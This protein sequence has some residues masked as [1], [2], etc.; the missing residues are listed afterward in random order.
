VTTIPG[1]PAL[2]TIDLTDFELYRSGF[3][4]DVFTVL[5]DEAPV[6]WH[7][8]SPSARF[9]G[10]GFWVVTRHADV[11]AVSRDPARFRS[12]EGPSLPEM[13]PERRGSMIVSMDP[14]AHTRLRRLV[15]AGFTPRMTAMLEEQARAWAR[16]IIDHALEHGECNFVQEVAYQLPMHLIADIVGIP[17]ADRAWLFDNVNTFIQSSDPRTRLTAAE[18]TALEAEL[19]TYAHELGA[20]KRRCPADDVWTTLTTAEVEH[21]DGTRTQL[22]E[23][24]LDLFFLVLT[25]AGSETTRNAIA[26]G[27][28][29][30]VDHPDQLEQL[31]SDPTVMPTA[32]EEILRWTTP[33]AYFR[34]TASEDT[35]I[36]GVPIAAGDRVTIWHPSANRDERAF[37]EPFRFD[38]TRADNPH[39]TFGGGGIH[40]CLGANL[41]KREIK[42]MFEELLSRVADVEVTGEP[43]YSVQ[44]IGNPITVSLQELP[45]RLTAR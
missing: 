35:E 21:D 6:W 18:R 24:E 23:L 27:L 13:P 26:S 38:I 32:V 12:F 22:S 4:H 16:S 45:V 5:R 30:L 11:Q 41:A 1:E 7:P 42:V 31:R 2:D 44:G 33:A 43:E 9:L 15:S 14:P 37:V 28:L 20:E 8:E 39:V 25:I 29:A 34:R 10:G 40:Y 19:Y 3:P 17:V 36:R